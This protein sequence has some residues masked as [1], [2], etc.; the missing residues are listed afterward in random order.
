MIREIYVFDVKKPSVSNDPWDDYM[1]KTTIPA[2]QAFAAVPQPLPAGQAVS[3]ARDH[4]ASPRTK[5]AL[6]TNTRT[7]AINPP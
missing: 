2:E 4:P 7:Q 1:L 5:W 6:V 3:R